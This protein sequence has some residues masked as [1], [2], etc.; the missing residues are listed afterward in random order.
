[1]EALRLYRRLPL[2]VRLHTR[3]RAWTC[4]FAPLLERVPAE[5]RLLEV[6]CGHGLF[7]NAAALDHPRLQV[8]GIDPSAEKIRWAQATVNGRANVRFA[9]A[10][11]DAV[12]ERDFDLLAVIDVLYLVPRAAWPDFLRACRERLRA[13]GRLLLKEVDVRPRWKFY[14]CLAQE[15]LSVRLLGITHGHGFDFAGREEMAGVLAAAGFARVAVTD[16][17]RGY[18]TPHVLYEAQR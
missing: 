9:Q 14:R 15:T 5:G 3:V 12:T 18:L 17:G 6:G 1:M 13:G 8:L 4:P 7:A 16:L 10:E 2:S 11:I